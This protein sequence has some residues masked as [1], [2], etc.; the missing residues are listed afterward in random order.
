MSTDPTSPMF[1]PI[2]P[3]GTHLELLKPRKLNQLAASAQ[4]LVSDKSRTSRIQTGEAW[5]DDAWDMYDLVGEQRFLASTLAN[6]MS[7]ARLFVGKQSDSLSEPEPVED[8]ALQEIL[9]SIG[10]SPGARAQIIRRLGVNLFIAGEGWLAGIPRW[11]LDGSEKPEEADLLEMGPQGIIEGKTL[12]LR[13][14]TWH[15]LSVTE[16]T[17][18]ADDLV[19]MKL[20]DSRT[21]KVNASEMLLYRIWRPHPRKAWQADS[22]TRSSLPVLRELVGLTMHT[23]AQIDSRLAGAGLLIVPSSATQALKQGQ[24]EGEDDDADPFT[25]ALLEAMLTPISD[26]SSA[27]AIVPLVVTAPDESTDKFKLLTFSQPLDAETREMRDEAIRRL[28]MGQDAPP[29]LLLGT[30]GM[31]HWGAW[32]VQEDVVSTHIEPPLALICDALTSQ[33]LWPVLESMG[34]SEEEAQQHVIWYDVSHMVARPN[35]AA[36]AMK[37]H[38]KGAISDEALRIAS[39]FDETDAPT[40]LQQAIDIATQM[41]TSAPDLLEKPGISA[42][43]QSLEDMLMD[44]QSQPVQVSAEAIESSGSG[45]SSSGES[46]AEDDRKGQDASLPNTENDDASPPDFATAQPSLNL[47]RVQSDVEILKYRQREKDQAD[48]AGESDDN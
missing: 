4:R 27:S 37:L 46:S 13:D 34:Y 14:L 15:T 30:G 47:A 28:A 26:R 11:F 42:L 2:P 20:E 24:G 35:R 44:R 9:D 40:I 8:Q 7:Q 36:D 23:S 19:T 17:S 21:I 16:V 45:E 33:Y 10:G 12:E 48:L 29:E 18:D 38:E 25:E 39:G 43:V 5:Q 3:P 41:V 32:L 1:L 31:N 22:P 6:R